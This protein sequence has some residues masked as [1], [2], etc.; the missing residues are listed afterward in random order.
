M[1]AF[2][3][4]KGLEIKSLVA[5]RFAC[6]LQHPVLMQRGRQRRKGER[7]HKQ[8]ARD[9][10]P[11]TQPFERGFDE[12][13]W[14]ITFHRVREQRPG[15]EQ[16]FAPATGTK[17]AFLA[18]FIQM[19]IEGIFALPV[20][21]KRRGSHSE[22]FGNGGQHRPGNLFDLH[23]RATRK[24]QECQLHGEAQAVDQL[25]LFLREG[26]VAG[27]LAIREVRWNPHKH[28]TLFRI[29][30]GGDLIRS[31]HSKNRS[32][33]PVFVSYGGSLVN[34][35]GGDEKESLARQAG[36]RRANIEHANP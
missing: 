9:D 22:L 18:Q 31:R 2:G 33:F 11:S 28:L 32:S 6:Q 3:G 27:N 5:A 4:A 20:L 13:Q 35:T 19:L 24:A 12:R 14:T 23:E 7:T 34:E 17:A 26:V 1:P 36:K 30:V 8:L 21:G 29:E 15:D 10:P 25:S 16:I